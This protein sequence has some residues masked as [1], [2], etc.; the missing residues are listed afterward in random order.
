M[1]AGQLLAAVV[2]SKA[3]MVVGNGA[4]TQRHSLF[5]MNGIPPSASSTP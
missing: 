2:L 1:S 5:Q 3:R 4:P